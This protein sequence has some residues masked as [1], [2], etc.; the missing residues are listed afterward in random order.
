[1]YRRCQRSSLHFSRY[2]S[3]SRRVSK[4]RALWPSIKDMSVVLEILSAAMC[5][6]THG[7]IFGS[8]L[9]FKTWYKAV[10]GMT[11]DVA[12]PTDKEDLLMLDDPLLK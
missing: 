1:M 4:F 12:Y 5:L 6:G 8:A 11:E 9:Q 10:E 3:L 7:P 2:Y